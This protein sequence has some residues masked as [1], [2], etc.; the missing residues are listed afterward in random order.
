MQ[1]AEPTWLGPKALLPAHCPLPT[2][3]WSLMPL[4]R[5]MELDLHQLWPLHITAHKRIPWHPWTS[6]RRSMLD[7]A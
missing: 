7:S 3:L 4:S 6:P 5:N 1:L 2:P